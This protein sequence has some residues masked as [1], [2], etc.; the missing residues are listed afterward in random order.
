MPW[1]HAVACNSKTQPAC[2]VMADRH[3]WA[4]SR[5]ALLHLTSKLC[6]KTIYFHAQLCSFPL[7]DQLCGAMVMRLLCGLLHSLCR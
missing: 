7:S 3:Q 6:T 5:Q 2:L 4:L 1:S